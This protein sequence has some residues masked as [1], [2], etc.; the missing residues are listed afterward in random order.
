M[1]PVVEVFNLSKKYKIYSKPW[2]RALEWVSLGRRKLHGENWALRDLNFTVAPGE[3]FGI[4]GRNGSG[5][6]TTLHTLIGLRAPTR[7]D[8]TIDGRP[9]P[10]WP[11]RQLA[12]RLG[13][14]TQVIE[15]PFAGTVMEAALVGRHPHIDFWRWESEHDRRIAQRCLETVGLAGL[16]AREV[17]TLSGGE[18]RRLAIATLLAQDPQVMLLDEPIQQLDPHHQ[19]D[20]LR[21]LRGLAERGR[22]VVMSLHD[23]GLAATYAD[24]A[25]LLSGDGR[26]QFGDV[27][28]VLTA[29]SIS[30]LYGL[31]LREIGWEGG[32]TFVPMQ[33][34]E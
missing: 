16:E 15:D 7:G 23:A 4:I 5:K 27:E 2:D 28:S 3:C 25:L 20:V 11:A 26:W 12:Q 31:R 29:G 30:E 22:T 13:L 18:R 9:L 21:L 24:H 10:A 19:V 17:A 6:S 33:P 14:L 32:R 34:T 8:I 1:E